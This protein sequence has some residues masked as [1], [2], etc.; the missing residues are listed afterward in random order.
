MVSIEGRTMYLRQ[1][2]LQRKVIGIT[3]GCYSA[4]EDILLHRLH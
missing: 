4:E 1:S 3:K 2:K